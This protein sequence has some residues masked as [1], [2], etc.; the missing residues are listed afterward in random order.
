MMFL[1]IGPELLHTC[2]SQEGP[3][4][5]GILEITISKAQDKYFVVLKKP[6]PIHSLV[7]NQKDMVFGG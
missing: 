2:S 3:L 1:Q 6:G 5:G 7:L 4:G